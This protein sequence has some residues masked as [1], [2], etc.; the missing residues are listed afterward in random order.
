MDDHL[1]ITDMRQTGERG[2]GSLS[3]ILPPLIRKHSKI[4]GLLF[5]YQIVADPKGLYTPT[6]TVSHPYIPPISQFKT[7]C[8]VAGY[9]SL[10]NERRRRRNRIRWWTRLFL[11]EGTRCGDNLSTDL[12]VEDGAGFRNVVRMTR[13]DSEVLLQMIG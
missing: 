13:T 11:K 8:P 9:I 2:K 7:S 4:W 10:L 12:K 5:C 6:N 3:W 1:C